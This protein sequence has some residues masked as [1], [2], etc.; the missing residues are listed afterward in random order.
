MSHFYYITLISLQKSTPYNVG[1]LIT[2][3]LWVVLPARYDDDDDLKDYS[4]I[5]RNIYSMVEDIAKWFGSISFV[6]MANQPWWVII[7]IELK[8]SKHLPIYII[9]LW[10]ACN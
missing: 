8:S 6:L 9:I 5:N 1:Y 10:F 2:I 4:V 7:K 3:L